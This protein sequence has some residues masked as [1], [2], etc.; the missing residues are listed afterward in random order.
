MQ[1]LQSFSKKHCIKTCLIVWISKNLFASSDWHRKN[2]NMFLKA[3]HL[4]IRKSFN[5]MLT[6]ADGRSIDFIYDTTQ[7]LWTV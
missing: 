5:V 3:I 2:F 7:W 6:I 4:T 1:K